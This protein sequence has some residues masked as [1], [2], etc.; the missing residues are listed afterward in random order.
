MMIDGPIIIPNQNK[1]VPDFLPFMNFVKYIRGT[2]NI[3]K[4]R[5]NGRTVRK[6]IAS[7]YSCSMAENRNVI[8]WAWFFGV[9]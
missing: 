6:I 9:L 8:I 2:W 7:R 5:K 1:Y 4:P 3:M